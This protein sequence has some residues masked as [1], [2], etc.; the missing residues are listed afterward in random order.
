MV[1]GGRSSKKSKSSAN[2]AFKRNIMDLKNRGKDIDRIQDELKAVAEGKVL[3]GV[4]D[5][6][7]PGGGRFYCVSCAR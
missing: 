7:N 4:I 5:E 2:R 1:R 6:D 3:P